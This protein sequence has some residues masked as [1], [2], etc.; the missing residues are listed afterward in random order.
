MTLTQL[1]APVL[2]LVLI[3]P[4]MATLGKDFLRFSNKTKI[5]AQSKPDINKKS[6]VL[7]VKYFLSCNSCLCGSRTKVFNVLTHLSIVY[8]L[9]HGSKVQN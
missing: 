3:L 8:G 9:T 5:S 2:D 6:F 7:K 1:S 4:L